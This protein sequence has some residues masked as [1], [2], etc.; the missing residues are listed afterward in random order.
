MIGLSLGL[1]GAFLG[2]GGRPFNVAALCLLFSMPTKLATQNS[3]LI[4]LFSQLSS[5]LQT[6][7]TTGVPPIDPILLGGMVIVAIAAS[8]VGRRIHRKIDNRQATFCL[9]GA[10]VLIIGISIYNMCKFF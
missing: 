5:T 1:L 2:I 9:E 8:E 10:M 6:L 3:L 4:V 7:F